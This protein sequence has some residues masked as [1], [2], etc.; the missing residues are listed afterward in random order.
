MSHYQENYEAEMST[1]HESRGWVL[2][3]G[4]NILKDVRSRLPNVREKYAEFL[5][6]HA[7]EIVVIELQRAYE[8]S[9]DE[10]DED[11][12][13]CIRKVLQHYMPASEYNIWQYNLREEMNE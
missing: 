4:K 3:A 2:R 1:A 9:L 6:N 7:D 10:G 5:D 11:T 13:Y 12:M 8:A